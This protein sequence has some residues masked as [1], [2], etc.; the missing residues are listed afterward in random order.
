VQNAALSRT[1]ERERLT[2]EVVNRL[3]KLES[4]LKRKFA[5]NWVS[6]RKAFLDLD[7]NNDGFISCEDIMK[8]FGADC[9]LNVNDLKKILVDNS[10]GK[11]GLLSYTDFSKWVGNSI[12]HI[13]GFYFRHD[14]VKNPHYE[15]SIDKYWKNKRFFEEKKEKEELSDQEIEKRVLE[16]MRLQWKTIQK[17]FHDIK[18]DKSGGIEKEELKYYLDFWQFDLTDE[19][20]DELFSKFDLDGDGKISYKEFQATVGRQIH[21]GE[22]LY[23]RQ[24]R[25]QL[26]RI[27]T[28][29]HHKCWQP[30][31]EAKFFCNLHQKMHQDFI[32]D[33][34]HR[35]YKEIGDQWQKFLEEVKRETEKDDAH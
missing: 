8:H 25:K 27:N 7:G 4:L 1:T 19:Q 6:V 2:S 20:F 28:C 34:I 14:S 18:K 3:K 22:V 35:L 21:P 16:K 32:G 33:V 17:A 26:Q 5:N 10:T 11:N 15:K 12:H 24:D 13:E 9:E 31:K 30:T 23:F 29:K